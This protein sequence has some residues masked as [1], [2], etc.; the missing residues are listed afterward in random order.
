MITATENSVIAIYDNHITAEETIRALDKLGFDMKKLSI[1]CKSDQ[2]EEHPVG[3]YTYN[4]RIKHWAGVGAFFGGFW[5]LLF[6]SAVFIV[7]GIG[8]LAL[9]GPIVSVLVA[10]LENALVVGGLSVLGA[11]LYNT[12]IAK[13]DVI[14]YETALMANKY[15]V[16]LHGNSE[17]TEKARELLHTLKIATPTE[18]SVD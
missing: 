5:G 2:T 8:L 14:K 10:G 7:P 18:A 16:I 4:D 6:G 3:F 11:A 13:E 1:I 15:I 17:E 9:A 12:G